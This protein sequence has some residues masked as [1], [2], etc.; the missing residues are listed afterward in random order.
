MMFIVCSRSASEFFDIDR[1]E[2]ESSSSVGNDL[3]KAVLKLLE[4]TFV[5]DFLD[6]IFR[7]INYNNS[8][9]LES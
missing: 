6:L 4:F 2:D 1:N 5:L 9:I 3:F 8:N 7:L